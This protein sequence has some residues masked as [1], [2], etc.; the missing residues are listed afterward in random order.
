[1]IGLPGDSY[2]TVANWV[3]VLTVG[4]MTTA[5]GG[6]G[7]GVGLGGGGGMDST[8]VPPPPPHAPSVR[9]K[10]D[11]VANRY[12]FLFDMMPSVQIAN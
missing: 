1:L 2:P 8:A 9:G 3:D 4:K 11:A 12:R 5:V 7:V 6:V 10:A